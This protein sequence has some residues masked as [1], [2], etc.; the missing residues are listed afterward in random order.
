VFVHR[1]AFWF[2]PR[3]A[4]AGHGHPYLVFDGR[5]RLH[6]PLIGFAKLA[7][8]QLAAS[9]VRV[10]LYALLP[11]FA[12]LD[13]TRPAAEQNG[14]WEMGP[15]GVRCAVAQYLEEEL[16]CVIR[17]HRL[18]FELVT[19]TGRSPSNVGVFLAA[20]KLFYSAMCVVQPLR[21]TPRFALIV[22]GRLCALLCR[23]R[24]RTPNVV[25]R[26]AQDVRSRPRS[27]QYICLWPRL[28]YR[29]ASARASCSVKRSCI[30]W[31]LPASS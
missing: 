6:L 23:V 12:F 7:S 28:S 27:T 17:R 5:D 16:G 22:S 11:F 18:G 20:L 31:R 1:G 8:R 21:H 10:Y 4:D 3:P 15:E 25:A 26:R 19:P 29:A 9:S 13:R 2:V 14:S 30:M 24:R